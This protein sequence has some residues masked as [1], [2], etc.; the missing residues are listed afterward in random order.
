MPEIFSKYQGYL[1]R[2]NPLRTEAKANKLV[3][4]KI[5]SGDKRQLEIIYKSHKF[6]FI[7]WLTNKFNCTEEEAKDVYQYAI[8]T[9][10]ENIKSE[11]LSELNSSVKTYLFAIGKHK[12][13]E[14]KKASVRFMPKLNEQVVDVPEV[15]KWE[16]EMYEE[17]LQLVERCLEIIGEPCKS[18]LEL[19]YY[20]NMSMEEIADRMNYKNRFTSKNLKYKCINRLRRT[21]LEELKKQKTTS[22]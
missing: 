10:Y 22:S 17:S 2:F 20:H 1:D 19:Y 7:S 9:F 8:M 13:L 16:N 3:I 18:L 11:R 15:G 6:E 12:I 14:Q 4:E 21:Y 5:K